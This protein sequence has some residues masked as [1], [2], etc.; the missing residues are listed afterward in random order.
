MALA[1]T[2]N[3]MRAIVVFAVTFAAV[4]FAKPLGY[5]V[6]ADGGPIFRDDKELYEFAASH[7]HLMFVASEHEIK[8]AQ[9]D[10]EA[11]STPE[12]V[13]RF[14]R[15]ERLEH[16]DLGALVIVYL[17]TW[18]G[19]Q[20]STDHIAYV[21]RSVPSGRQLVARTEYESACEIS[22]AAPYWLMCDS[23][24]GAKG[25]SWQKWNGKSFQ[26]QATK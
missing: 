15:A 23:Y 6:P 20:R 2:G 14:S 10:K 8:G 19:H 7:E 9:P 11:I 3:E 18:C 5:Q 21:L 1:V 24:H 4:S 16:E 17:P 12:G 22:K 25:W 26:S 13:Q